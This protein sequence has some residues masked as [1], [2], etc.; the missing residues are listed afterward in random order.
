MTFSPRALGSTSLAGDTPRLLLV[1]SDAGSIGALQRDFTEGGYDVVH[2]QSYE[3]G[4]ALLTADVP[5]D[6]VVLDIAETSDRDLDVCRRYRLW[7]LFPGIATVVLLDAERTPIEGLGE[8]VDAVLCKPFPPETLLARVRDAVAA[9]GSR[10]R[11]VLRRQRSHEVLVRRTRGLEAVRLLTADIVRVLDFPR[12]LDLIVR[13]ARDLMDAAGAVLWT[14]DPLGQRLAPVQWSGVAMGEAERVGVEIGGGE[15]DIRSAGMHDALGTI[16]RRADL[17]EPLICRGNVLGAITLTGLARNPDGQPV[18]DRDSLVMFGMSAAIALEN[19]RLHAQEVRRSEELEALLSALQVITSG[20][21]LQDVLTRLVGVTAKISKCP[22]VSVALLDQATGQ[23]QTRALLGLASVQLKD[24][25]DVADSLP[26]VAFRTGEPVFSG[27]CREDARNG[28]RTQDAVL[29]LASVLCLPIRTSKGILGV[30]TLC[31]TTPHDDQLRA[32]GYLKTLATHVAVAVEQSR[33]NEELSAYIELRELVQKELVRAEKLRALG[34]LSAGVAHDLNNLLAIVTARA[35]VILNRVT[36]EKTQEAARV[37]FQAASDSMDVVRRVQSFA[38]QDASAQLT[39]CNLPQ[40]V[41]ETLE[42]SRDRWQNGPAKQRRPIH[43]VRKIGVLPPVLG[44]Q[45]EIREA[46]T[47]LILNAVD[48]M[49]QGG[50]LSFVGAPVTDTVGRQW[51][52]LRVSDTGRGIPASLHDKIF[53]PFFT[54]KGVEGTGLGLSVVYGIMQR[55]GGSISVVSTEGKGTTFLLRFVADASTPASSPVM[56]HRPVTT[57]RILIVDDDRSVR[58]ALRA[59][60]QSVGH[61]VVETDTVDAALGVVST[62]RVDLICTDIRLPG[63][64]GFFLVE[65]LRETGKPVIVVTGF[66]DAVDKARALP[67]VVAV[68]R[69]PIDVSTFIK[70]VADVMKGPSQRTA[71]EA[72]G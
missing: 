11:L 25:V 59:L 64:D 24:L 13:G 28:N 57:Y 22:N 21:R 30:L 42:L 8:W 40:L 3:S 16:A 19:A 41:L 29:G 44:T 67:G 17:V 62:R 48:A 50:T 27:D 7:N 38:R 45:T 4:L 32:Q 46:I 23:L 69:K 31:S 52:E 49:P 68:L 51:V 18:E 5:V 2:V 60:L 53:D 26:G 39:R 6:A 58:C 12:L 10:E 66:D 36:D 34:E 1:G 47:N 71:S 55:F 72:S 14:V 33:M 65:K 56:E 35:Q 43:A 70:T 61:T 15:T 63:K 37:L 20:E 9:V 54:T